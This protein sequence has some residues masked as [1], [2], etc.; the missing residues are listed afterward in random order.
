MSD[1]K[2]L[3]LKIIHTLHKNGYEAYLAGGCVRDQLLGKEPKDYDI[4]T[5]ALPDSIENLFS[6]T[7]AIGKS[8]GTIVVIE[9]NQSIEVTTFRSESTYQDGRHPEKVIFSSAKK[10]ASRRDFT[11]NGLFYDPIKNNVIDSVSYT[12]LTLPTNRE[13]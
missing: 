9:H 12:H 5:N 13:V 3:A 2:S 1:Q 7:T 4:A 6:K 10:D 8:F 11:I